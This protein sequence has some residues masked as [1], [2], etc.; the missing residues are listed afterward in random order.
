MTESS[1]GM[2]LCAIV[3]F[4]ICRCFSFIYLYLHLVLLVERFRLFI[5]IYIYI[6]ITERRYKVKSIRTVSIRTKNTKPTL[7]RTNKG[8]RINIKN[9][10][11]AISILGVF[12][13][14]TVLLIATFLIGLVPLYYVKK[15]NS[16]LASKKSNQMIGILS[17]FG[18]GML[19]GTSF[20][21]VIPEGIKSCLEHDG[22]VGLN[23]LIGFLVV[24]L[25]DRLVQLII[26]RKNKSVDFEQE[27]YVS[28]ESLT[29]LVKN[30]RRIIGCILRNNVVFALFIHGL[31]DGIALGTTNNNDSL[32]IIVLIAIVIH[33]IPAV[34]S[35]SSLMIS[36]QKLPEWEVVSNL[37]AFALSTPLGYICLSMF[38]LNHSETM[39]WIS[40]NLLLMSGGSL[41]YASFTAFVTGDKDSNNHSH[42]HQIFRNSEN[43]TETDTTI[44]HEMG[45]SFQENVDDDT[46]LPHDESLYVVSG[47]VLPLLIS[48]FIS[49]D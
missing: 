38:N 23:L 46:K 28:F 43:E 47:V 41:L 12:L 29:D 21:L 16:N 2:L 30:P 27:N 5:Y 36:K 48:F 35:L 32:L 31:S 39:D 45:N 40:G 1:M 19:L 42:T 20:M 34:L 11:M 22:N 3:C 10:N 24:Y 17:Q 13:M 44:D 6:C 7:R 26:N 33:K 49:E 14:S 8:L 9:A 37:F 15:Q 4:Y 18:V 25:L